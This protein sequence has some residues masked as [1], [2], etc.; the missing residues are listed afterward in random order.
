MF[1][2]Y[3]VPQALVYFSVLEYSKELVERLKRDP[4]LARGSQEEAEI[5]GNSIW[6]VELVVRE[7]KRL[8]EKKG[9]HG[10]DVL[11]NS[12]L[13][14]FYLWDFAKEKKEEMQ[15]IPI[16]KTESIFY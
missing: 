15:H 8:L 5:R 7:I 1:A 4:F 16:H 10:R 3:R 14:D 2:D 11:V 13:L 6:S 9:E 12:V